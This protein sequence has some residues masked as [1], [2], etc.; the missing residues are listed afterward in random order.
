MNRHVRHVLWAVAFCLTASVSWDVSAQCSSGY[1][2]YTNR[3][4]PYDSD[5]CGEGYYC[6]AG[7]E[8]VGY[9]ASATCHEI[10]AGCSA[11]QY[12]CGGDYCCP[13]GSTYCGGG[14]YCLAG[15]V[16]VEGGGCRSTGGSGTGGCSNSCAY[17]YDGECDDGG[18]GAAYSVCALGTDCAD[19]G[20]RGSGGGGGGG[21]DTCASE[22]QSGCSFTSCFTDDSTCYYLY[23]SQRF[24]CGDCTVASNISS[25][26]DRAVNAC[27]S[28]GPGPGPG[29]D[30][31]EGCTVSRPRSTSS[32]LLCLL[33]IAA[34]AALLRRRVTNALH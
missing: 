2:C 21:E 18:P 1:E 22:T 13:T 16:C 5:H 12:E 23:G 10:A 30:P 11:G 25:C 14:R 15:T 8:C 31:A 34:T 3:C 19:C 7:Y 29:D 6:D 28:V 26:A 17:A 33:L 4:C 9:G 32:P 27:L 20:T 24:D